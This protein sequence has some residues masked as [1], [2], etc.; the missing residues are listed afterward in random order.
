MVKHSNYTYT[1][2]WCTVHFGAP[3]T[4]TIA[5]PEDL[6]NCMVR[7]PKCKT[8]LKKDSYISTGTIMP[9]SRKKK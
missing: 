7:C 8:F 5:L 1:C 6:H 9:I 3:H 4:F 2:T